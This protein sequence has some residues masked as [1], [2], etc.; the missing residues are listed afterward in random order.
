EAANNPEAECPELRDKVQMKL[1]C[2]AD[3][4]EGVTWRMPSGRS[5]LQPLMQGQQ[6]DATR[7]VDQQAPS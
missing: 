5:L 1:L 4:T 7:S 2:G 6:N 3:A